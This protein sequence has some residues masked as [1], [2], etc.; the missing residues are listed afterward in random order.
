MMAASH[1]LGGAAAGIMVAEVMLTGNSNLLLYAAAVSG[2]VLGSLIPDIDNSRSSISRSVPI[3]S[4]IVSVFQMIVRGIAVLLPLSKKEENHIRGVV[5]HRGITHSLTG[6]AITT[7]LLM[8]IGVLLKTNAVAGYKI[9]SIG[10]IAGMLSH[11]FLDMFAGGAPLFCP[12]TNK[13]VTLARVKTGGAVEWI[14]RLAAIVLFAIIFK[15][16]INFFI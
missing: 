12:I 15:N 5:G 7:I 13:R 10:L 11:I 4:G 16:K 2:A 1:R 14:I 6:C 8:S 3:V 9:F